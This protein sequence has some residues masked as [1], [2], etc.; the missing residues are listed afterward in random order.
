MLEYKFLPFGLS[1][2]ELNA[3]GILGIEIGVTICV[4]GTIIVIFDALSRREDML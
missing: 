1:D 2:K 4:M 3:L